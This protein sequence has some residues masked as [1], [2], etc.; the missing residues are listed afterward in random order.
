MRKHITREDYQRLGAEVSSSA[1]KIT[2][3]DGVHAAELL[4][5]YAVNLWHLSTENRINDKSLEAFFNAITKESRKYT[6]KVITHLSQNNSEY[7]S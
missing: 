5:R 6:T 2:G 7:M 4:L 1:L 3:G